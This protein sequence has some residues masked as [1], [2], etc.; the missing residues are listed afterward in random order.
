MSNITP[1][2]V[3]KSRV[4]RPTKATANERVVVIASMLLQAKTRAEIINFCYDNYSLKPTS[5]N[6]LVTLAYKYIA[7]THQ[8]DRDATVILHLQYYYEL[9]AT[10]KALGD[11]R[12]AVACLNSIEKLMKLTTPDALI[13]QNS[14]NVNLKDMT[15]TD[16]KELLQL[17]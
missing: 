16:L 8:V 13:Q 3:Y 1:R 5:V 15:L 10:A 12:G 14:L 17:K 9:Y 7:E 2:N 11:T 6:N 4:G